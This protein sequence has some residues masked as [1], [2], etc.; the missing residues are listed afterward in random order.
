MKTRGLDEQLAHRKRI[1]ALRAKLEMDEAPPAGWITCAQFA[2]HLDK[3]HRWAWEQLQGW[4]RKDLCEVKKF[5]VLTPLSYKYLPH[6]R[7]NAEVAEAYGLPK[8][9]KA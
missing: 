8:T 1:A 4:I 5:K 2:S 3:S 9:P 7:L 6:Y